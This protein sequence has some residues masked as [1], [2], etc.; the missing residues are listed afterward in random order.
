MVELHR[1]WN[2][3]LRVLN[4]TE[5]VGYHGYDILFKRAKIMDFVHRGSSNG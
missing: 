3:R 2:D 1:K 4:D 5:I